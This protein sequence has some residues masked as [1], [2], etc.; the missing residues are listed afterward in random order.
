VGCT[1]CG[2]ASPAVPVGTLP[3]YTVPDF[4]GKRIAAASRWVAH[5]TLYF[6]E[7]IGP[8]EAGDAGS[9]FANYRITAQYPPPGT[10]IA[11]GI[12]T[13]NADR[14]SGTFT[15]TPLTISADQ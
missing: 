1:G 7:R 14:T 4:V 10:R 9:L 8:L 2:L 11:L 5:K 15:P 3:R 13:H 12:G 6:T